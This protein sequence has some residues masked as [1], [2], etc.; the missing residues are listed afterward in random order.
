MSKVKLDQLVQDISTKKIEVLLS[1]GVNTKN[2]TKYTTTD[3]TDACDMMGLVT[4]EQHTLI[5]DLVL[6]VIRDAKRIKAEGSSTYRFPHTLLSYTVLDSKSNSGLIGQLYEK[7]TYTITLSNED[8]KLFGENVEKPSKEN[9]NRWK[10]VKD[11][12][13][14]ETTEIVKDN[15]HGFTPNYS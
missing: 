1:N 5:N 8:H 11:F 4:D 13:D 3:I 6:Q 10:F 12:T 14:P 9:G 2:P 7:K 15:Q